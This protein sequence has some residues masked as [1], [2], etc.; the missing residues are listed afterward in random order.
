MKRLLEDNDVALAHLKQKSEADELK[1][2]Y[3]EKLKEENEHM[4]NERDEWAKKL[5]S[6]SK[7]GNA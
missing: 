5:H 3:F 6:I 2:V 4:K 7:R 1:L